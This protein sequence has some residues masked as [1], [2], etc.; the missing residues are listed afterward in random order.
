VA[1]LTQLRQGTGPARLLDMVQ[2]RSKQAFKTWLAERPEAWRDAVEVVAMDG[3]TGFKTAAAAEELSDAVAVMDPFHV[4]RLAG[5]ALD[6]C[7]RRVQL[8]V[9]GHRGHKGDPLNPRAAPCTPERTSSP[10]SRSTGSPRCSPT[11]PTPRT[12]PPGGQAWPS[13]IPKLPDSSA[14]HGP[15]LGWRLWAPCASNWPARSTDRYAGPWG[16][17]RPRPPILLMNIRWDPSTAYRNAVVAEQRLG[18]AVLLTEDGY[19]HLTFNDPSQCV[20]QARTRYLVG[21]VPPARGTVCKAD[22]L[23][24]S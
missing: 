21:L 14:L 2:G 12:R 19:G 8:A 5:Q 18:N 7:R 6:E 10:T 13:V 4:V 9:H 3:F 1:D 23:P 24:V 16:A 15:L 11:T 17:P 20:D 22:K